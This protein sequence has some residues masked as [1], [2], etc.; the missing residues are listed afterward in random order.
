MGILPGLQDDCKAVA[1]NRLCP[2]RNVIFPQFVHRYEAHTRP[3][4]VIFHHKTPLGSRVL[5][6]VDCHRHS[7]YAGVAGQQSQ[8]QEKHFVEDLPTKSNNTWW[9]GTKILGTFAPP[10]SLQLVAERCWV[11]I[12]PAAEVRENCWGLCWNL[13]QNGSVLA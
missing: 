8:T 12:F 9:T 10:C 7:R 2:K 1:V 4:S 5:L 3:F 6:L 13:S 11:C